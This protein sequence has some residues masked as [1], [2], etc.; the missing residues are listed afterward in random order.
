MLKQCGTRRWFR[1]WQWWSDHC[2]WRPCCERWTWEELLNIEFV[3]LK[4]PLFMCEEII[5]HSP[6]YDKK[7]ELKSARQWCRKYCSDLSDKVI[8][9][10]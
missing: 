2:R 1:Y 10:D 7:A 3:V 6:R 9:R 4:I 5:R 8:I